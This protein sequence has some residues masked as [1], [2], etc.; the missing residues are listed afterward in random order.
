MT[1]ATKP[2][3]VPSC[4]AEAL[5]AAYLASAGGDPRAA[6]RAVVADA[7]ADLAET[8]RRTRLAMQL[9]SR[10]YVRGTSGPMSHQR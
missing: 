8:E 10:G 4:P 1:A 3:P 9:V 5:V 2:N 7:L 6:L